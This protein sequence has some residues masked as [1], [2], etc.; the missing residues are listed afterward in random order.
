M[1]SSRGLTGYPPKH[2][3]P[4]PASPFVSTI[5]TRER[6]VKD[7]RFLS[8][9]Q[10]TIPRRSQ[11]ETTDHHWSRENQSYA[12]PFGAA[13]RLITDTGREIRLRGRCDI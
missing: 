13:R 6:V 4:L 3:W 7:T 12:P 11:R 5:T 2:D 8:R 1:S 10:L 9:C